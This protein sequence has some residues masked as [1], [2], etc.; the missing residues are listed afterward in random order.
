[1]TD[2]LLRLINYRNLLKE[3]EIAGE[4]HLKTILE[5]PSE[6]LMKAEKLK[7]EISSDP[8]LM[9]E[10]KERMLK[11]VNGYIQQVSSLSPKPKN[12]EL[13][14]LLN[15]GAAFLYLIKSG[16]LPAFVEELINLIGD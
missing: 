14:S 13:K 12:E 9:A 10:D 3:I 15:F 4:E 5:D 1:M 16:A 11:K 7:K 2:Y 6:Y 8:F